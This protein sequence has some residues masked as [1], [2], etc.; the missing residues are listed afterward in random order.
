MRDMSAVPLRGSTSTAANDLRSGRRGADRLGRE[1]PL[2]A[3]GASSNAAPCVLILF[4]GLAACVAWPAAASA[5]DENVIPG[6]SLGLVYEPDY[7]RPLAVM[8]FFGDGADS[9]AAAVEAERIV[10]RDLHNSDRFRVVDSLPASL[11]GGGVDYELWDDFGVDLLVTGVVEARLG[12]RTLVIELHDVVYARV[13]ERDRFPI[14]SPSHA[15]FRMAIH[16][17]ADAIV[18]WATG[19]PGAAATRIAFSMRPDPTDVATEIYLVDSDGENLRRLTRDE[20]NTASPTWAPNGRALAY[21]SWKSGEPRI[22]ERNLADGS[23]R[24]LQPGRAGQQITPA[25]HPGGVRL[26]F[27]LLGGARGGLF[28]YALGDDC[29]L[30]RLGGGRY[31]NVQPTYSP[32]GTEIAFTS[33]RLGVAT[34]QVYVM[35]A[36]GGE[37]R[38]LSP[39]RYGQGGYFTDPDWSPVSSK[40]AFAGRIRGRRTLYQILVADTKTGDSRLIQLTRQGDNQDPSW[41]P[42]GR[43]IV[44]TAERGVYVVDSGT[45]RIRQL[46]PV[47][48]ARAEDPDWSLPLPP[49]EG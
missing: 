27:A 1:R 47:R 2:G 37:A 42:D 31:R 43:H 34:P 12:G 36:N 49:D 44:F 20:S 23:E 11:A 15:G 28:E 21:T 45:G 29:C 10:A 3:S 5:Q 6:V 41:A 18:L 30:S 26:A 46:A 16:R 25:Y 24:M 35:P 13:L 33:D 48:G 38:L 17:A 7:L 14:P 39:Y 40:V 19:D 22:Y 4:A 9:H 32:D 8:P